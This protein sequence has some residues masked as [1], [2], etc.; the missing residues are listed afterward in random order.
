[1]IATICGFPFEVEY[2]TVESACWLACKFFDDKANDTS[3]EPV[4]R[5]FWNNKLKEA[6]K[7]FLPEF[8]QTC[9]RN[10]NIAI[11]CNKSESLVEKEIRLQET[12]R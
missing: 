6:R 2:F 3:L 12:G 4:E 11:R 1:M 10:H 7:I 8:C 9:N 5:K